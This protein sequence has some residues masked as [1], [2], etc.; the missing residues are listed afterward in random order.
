MILKHRIEAMCLTAVLLSCAISVS[1]AA[2]VKPTRCS[3]GG[4]GVEA[5]TASRLSCPDARTVAK[6]WQRQCLERA[7]GGQA[8]CSMF[9]TGQRVRCQVADVTPPSGKVSTRCSRGKW[10]VRFRMYIGDQ[11]I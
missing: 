4:S 1:P 3:S 9:V 2:A 7:L 8:A 10:V 11:G 5:L 6:Q